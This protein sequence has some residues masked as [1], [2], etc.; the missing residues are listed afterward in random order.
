MLGRTI[1]FAGLTAVA[2][3]TFGPLLGDAA[4]RAINRPAGERPVVTVQPA[5]TPQAQMVSGGVM[6]LRRDGDSHFR[7]PVTINGHA[8][9]MLV[10]SGA[11]MV[12]LNAADARAIGI[13]P[14]DAAFTGRAR[15]AAG[16]VAVAPVTIPSLRIGG[17]EQRDVPAM[18]L[19]GDALPQPLLGQSFLSRLNEVSIRDD[20][21]TLR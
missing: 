8:L 18:V 11:S 13:Q 14:P 21:M 5:A 12:V 7:V 20:R 17:I 19:R 9:T 15:T 2:F 6:E 3:A 1:L 16:E 4:Q 10:D